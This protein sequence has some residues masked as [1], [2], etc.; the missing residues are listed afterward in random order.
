VRTGVRLGT[1]LRLARRMGADNESAP[2]RTALDTGTLMFI[3]RF[4][5]SLSDEARCLGSWSAAPVVEL[6]KAVAW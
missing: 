5:D 1:L 4:H 3:I 2:C 6:M